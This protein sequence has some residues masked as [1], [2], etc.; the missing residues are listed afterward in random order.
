MAMIMTMMIMA[1]MTMLR[2]MIMIPIR[3]IVIKM[4][5]VTMAIVT[6]IKIATMMVM[7]ITITSDPGATIA[8]GDHMSVSISTL[9]PLHSVYDRRV[10]VHPVSITRF[11]LS[12]FSP[13]AGLLRTPFVHR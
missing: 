1:I 6:M 12:R 7:L 9:T 10:R 11:P 3:I 13:G 5:M 8:I 4:T 2:I